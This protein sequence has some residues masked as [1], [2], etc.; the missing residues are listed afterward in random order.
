MKN[1]TK[2]WLSCSP[3]LLIGLSVFLS[4]LLH[5]FMTRKQEATLRSDPLTMK[6]DVTAETEAISSLNAKVGGNR[7]VIEIALVRLVMPAKGRSSGRSRDSVQIATRYEGGG[8]GS[9]GASDNHRHSSEDI[10]FGSRH[11]FSGPRYKYGFDVKQGCL[12]LGERRIC[13]VDTPKLVVLGAD[14]NIVSV[15]DL[16][17]S[18]PPLKGSA[19]DVNSLIASAKNYAKLTPA[20]ILKKQVL[21]PKVRS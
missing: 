21:E 17:V 19:S 15:T 3:L 9:S 11:E 2:L 14:G 4:P 8:G 13:I 10:S 1:S 7:L 18:Y 20:E 16:N 12:C 5:G 6:V